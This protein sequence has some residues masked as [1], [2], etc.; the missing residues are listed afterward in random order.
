MNILPR[1]TYSPLKVSK[2]LK[3]SYFS[4]YIKTQY[5]SLIRTSNYEID[6]GHLIKELLSRKFEAEYKPL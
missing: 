5:S 1:L 4:A 2:D 6:E 3:S